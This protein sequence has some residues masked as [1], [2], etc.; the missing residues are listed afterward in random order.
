MPSQN[1]VC[2]KNTA[3]EFISSQTLRG[4]DTELQTERER[5]IKRER[6]RKR[7]KGCD[8][9]PK[10]AISGTFLCWCFMRF[11]PIAGRAVDGA[12]ERQRELKTEA[13]SRWRAASFS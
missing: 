1:T 4:Q 9:L 12:Y 11:I 10:P 7:E 13:R 5:E 2:A 6:K 8:R 3:R